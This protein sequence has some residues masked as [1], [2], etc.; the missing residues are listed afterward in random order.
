MTPDEVLEK[1]KKESENRIKRNVD[2]I[3]S[4]IEENA[5]YQTEFKREILTQNEW[6]NIIHK[7]QEDGR[8]LAVQ[9]GS[10]LIWRLFKNPNYELNKSILLTN[11]VQV[12]SVF[13]TI[14]TLGITIGIQFMSYL[15]Q[16]KEIGIQ[17][18]QL[19][20][21]KVSQ[22][23]EFLKIYEIKEGMTSNQ[24]KLDSVLLLK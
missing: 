4:K 10:N 3:V 14:F 23:Q 12:V 13:T 22:R 7:I 24:R 15:T 18:E 6:Y 21:Q 20:M 16:V 19:E 17:R 11:K 8:Y 2:Y 5:Y 1:N 9:D